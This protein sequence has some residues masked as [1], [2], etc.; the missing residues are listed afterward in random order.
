MSRASAAGLRM[1]VPAGALNICVNEYLFAGTRNLM[2]VLL[3]LWAGILV[4]FEMS[5]VVLG[6]A[7]SPMPMLGAGREVV[8]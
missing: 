8:P 2:R 5:A 6:G 1:A 4:R 3:K 7:T